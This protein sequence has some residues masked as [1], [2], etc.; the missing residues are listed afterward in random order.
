M[1]EKLKLLYQRKGELHTTIEIAQAQMQNVNS[2][3]VKLLNANS[4]NGKEA[5]VKK[6]PN[7][8]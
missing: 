8:I 6:E 1:D 2:E 5:E 7:V 3:I 4:T